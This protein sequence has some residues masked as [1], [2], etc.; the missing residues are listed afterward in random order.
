MPKERTLKVRFSDDSL[1]LIEDAAIAL[2]IEKSIFIRIAAV[3]KANATIS[4]RTF[5]QR[6]R[7]AVFDKER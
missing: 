4:S 1:K 3:E 2:D 6:L 7:D 5:G